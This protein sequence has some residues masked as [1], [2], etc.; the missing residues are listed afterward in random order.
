MLSV[1]FSKANTAAAVA[2]L[3]WFLFYAP[4][5]F[6][7]QNYDLLTLAQK[8]L[9]SLFSNTAMAFGFQLIIRWE[10]T[11]EGL[12][13]SN[14]FQPLSVD[15]NFNVGY[16]WVMLIVDSILYLGIT[17]YVE[18]IYP[19]DFGVPEPWYFLFTKKFWCGQ[20]ATS[21]VEVLD[22]TLTVKQQ[23]HIEADPKGKHA[24]I[25]VRALRKVYRNK[26]V[27]VANFTMNMFD[28]QITVL[29]GHNGA[30]KTTT[31]SMLTGMFTPTSGT[32]II[33]GK[34][35]R[36]DIGGVRNSLGLCPQHNILFDELTVRE[37]IIFYSRLKGLHG[38]D[39][40]AEVQK[41]VKLLELE[42]KINAMSK[43]LS[44]GMKRKL[45]VGVALCGRSKVVLCDEPSSGMD[46]AARRALWDLLQKEKHGR[47][48]LL[49]TH[50]MD[51]ADILGDRIA[52]LANGELKCIGSSFFLKKRFG[53]GYHLICV[54]GPRCQSNDVT[55][56]LS[57]YVPD[58]KV[59][60]D[61]GTELSYQLN[62]ANSSKFEIMLKDLENN[63]EAL[64]LT[65]YGVSLTTLEEVFMKVGTD[66]VK[67]I[68]NNDENG[69]VDGVPDS[70]GTVASANSTGSNGH[71]SEFKCKFK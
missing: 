64:G 53:S 36:Y 18:Q 7:Q 38:K 57:K 14:L 12:Q 13:W 21:T 20:S 50:F 46:P 65:N 69:N 44:G 63:S 66:P 35:I 25:Q 51:E 49:S 34:D 17:L 43:S 61:I 52:I 3:V 10:G 56:L 23:D 68:N 8:L 11:G 32:A 4:Y 62:D 31:M 54:K 37:H 27:A 47:T 24:G 28:D 1:F 67:P 70:N 15:E 2:G 48:I 59:E 16:T 60:N 19:G 33:N 29:L 42:N 55:E 41:Y 58:V 45:S 22:D 71:N 30:G 6:T 39:I 5:T 9:V 40:D 26:K